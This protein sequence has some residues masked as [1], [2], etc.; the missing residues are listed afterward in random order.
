MKKIS[1]NPMTGKNS[2]L[3]LELDAPWGDVDG[4]GVINNIQNV[5]IVTNGATD[6]QVLGYQ[7]FD[8]V[9]HLVPVDGGS[10][11]G[12]PTSRLVSTENGLSGGGAL[13]SDLTLSP[14]YGIAANTVCEGNDSRLI[15]PNADGFQV[16]G[17]TTPR[18]FLLTSGDFN[19]FCDG[20]TEFH[21][22]GT[23]TVSS[24]Y[25][26]VSSAIAGSTISLGGDLLTTGAY[27]T[28]FTQHQ[29]A[30]FDLPNAATGT[31]AT[32][33]GVEKLTNKEFVRRVGTTITAT[34]SV[35]V[36]AGEWF[37]V[38]PVSDTTITLD[39]T[40]A[41]DGDEFVFVKPGTEA[42][43]VDI[44][45]LYTIPSG[46]QGGATVKRIGGA[47]VCTAGYFNA[48]GS[49]LMAIQGGT[50]Q[51]SN[52][53]GDILVASAANTWDKLPIGTAG[54][55]PV[56]N[57]GATGLEYQSLAQMNTGVVECTITQAN[58][59]AGLSSGIVTFN[60]TFGVAFPANARLLGSTIGEGVFAT[61]DNGG[62]AATYVVALGVMNGGV[63]V[64]VLTG[65]MDVSVETAV[66]FPSPGTPGPSGF[67]MAPGQGATPIMNITSSADLNTATIGTVTAKIFY[68]VIPEGA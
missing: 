48:V 61:Y 43:S 34:G 38:V 31:L 32:L 55:I 18:Q 51:S 66:S 62:G 9:Q 54:Q 52:T 53:Q 8:G 39:A 25:T 57:A 21:L 49:T 30:T 50:G 29:T 46:R 65:N 28:S 36:A 44:G 20:Y 67:I 26:L 35:T 4:V 41:V 24:S 17:G 68:V 3:E 14:T 7:T 12:V 27:N 64:P 5:P 60:Q 6:G 58:D 13:S 19:V 15:V 37:E 40:G 16:S 47:W 1:K 11:G 56:V 23:F 63:F 22:A 42:F 10:G 2:L 45:G 33:A 59:L